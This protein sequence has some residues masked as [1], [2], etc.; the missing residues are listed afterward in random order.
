MRLDDKQP[1]AEAQI[2]TQ[3]LKKVFEKSD[4]HRQFA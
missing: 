2:L 4:V 1:V 3:I